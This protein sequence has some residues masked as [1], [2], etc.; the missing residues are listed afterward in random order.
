MNR[1]CQQA[2]P[3][4]LRSWSRSGSS[5][6][7]GLG[8][9]R[10][11]GVA[12]AA[13]CVCAGLLPQ[14][15]AQTW[16]QAQAQA[17]QA[18]ES[19]NSLL[20]APA[21]P[22]VAPL[23]PAPGGATESLAAL[24]GRVL[25]RDP[26]VRVADSLLQATQQRRLQ[27]R[28]RL[29][30]SVYLSA[31]EGGSSETEFG[32]PINRSTSRS[33]AGLR[34]NLYN[35]GNDMAELNGATRDIDVAEQDLRRAREEVAERIAETYTDLLRLQTLL[36]HALQR[37][38]AVRKLVE[39]VRQQTAAGK[40]SEAD[41][42]QAATSLLDAEIAHE[43]LVAD[44]DAARHKLS[45]QVGGEV[46]DAE[47]L[48]LPLQW[49][50]AAAQAPAGA[51]VADASLANVGLA[52]AG[53]ANASGLVAAARL[54]ADAARDRV[55]PVVSLLAPRI[56]LEVRHQVHDRTVPSPTTLQKDV[57]Q[58]TA[59]WD[60]PVMGENAARRTEQQR[61]AEAAVAEAERVA[62]GMQIELQTLGPRIANA[63]RALAQ[64]E[65]QAA[66]YT[67]LV[68]AG[69]LQ[70]E[71]GRRSVAQLIQL[72]DSRFNVE[73]RRSEQAQRLLSAQLKLLAL[74]GRLLPALGLGVN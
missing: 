21:A 70:F 17:K 61:R 2:G 3:C 68:R 6:G 34:W 67:S 58:I 11:R 53:L 1:S 7:L 5:L 73:Q 74:Q 60:F 29:G 41:A 48:N 20:D 42:T 49:L 22:V 18:L 23:A 44:L 51:G 71:A 30:P 27:A 24:L 69:E 46:R 55:R 16:G 40:T 45:A 65:R 52:N 26:Q 9:V 57:W 14:A 15:G 38:D 50:S 37:L 43:L 59:R 56:D 13:L 4:R 47:P 19:V 39:Q 12:A 62:Q 32:F 66:Q 54:R 10:F 33:E 63:E 64:L 35:A 72:R 28:S 36:P 25:P 31:N 8:M